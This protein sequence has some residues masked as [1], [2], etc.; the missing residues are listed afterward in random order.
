VTQKAKR[1]TFTAEYKKSI[2]EKA[3]RA[4]ASGEKGALGALLRREGLY[5]SHL[6]EW[7]E[8]RERG[9]IAGLTPKRRG[10]AKRELDQRDR[11]IAELEHEL[12]KKNAR[13]QR[14]EEYLV[15]VLRTS[16]QELAAQPARFTPR[17]W[18]EETLLSRK[19]T[20]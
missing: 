8:A 9:E 7:R 6:T 15:S 10:P 18:A 1:R 11:R 16:E 20:S 2:L 13:L 17:A 12:A 3:D 14:A 19:L 4:V 5:S